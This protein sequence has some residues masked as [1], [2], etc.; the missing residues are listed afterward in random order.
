MSM[1]SI[2]NSIHF[3][4][5][6][7]MARLIE[8]RQMSSVEVT[9]YMHDRIEAVDGK[10]KSY[11]AVMVDGAIEAARNAEQEIAGGTY[12]GPLHGIPIAV[13]LGKLNLTEGAMAGYHTDFAIPV[14]PWNPEY[15][16][17]VSSSGSGVAT[18]A[19]LC[20]ASS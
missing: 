11:A 6:L 20:F 5:L 10:L 14:N 3:A 9:R 15:W 13:L 17:G 1:G 12:R 18:A 2:D 16:S 8:S 19:G 4:S 7:D